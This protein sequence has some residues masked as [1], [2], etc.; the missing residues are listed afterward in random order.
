MG[1]LRTYHCAPVCRAC[2][3]TDCAEYHGAPPAGPPPREWALRPLTLTVT[4]GVR[5]RVCRRVPQ[6]G[7]PEP[8]AESHFCAGP[9]R[10]DWHASHVFRT[11]EGGADQTRATTAST[12][13]PRMWSTPSL[14]T[15]TRPCWHTLVPPSPSP[16]RP[17]S[18]PLT[19]PLL[20]PQPRPPAHSNASLPNDD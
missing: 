16:L 9:R 3:P 5:S 14:R 10:G 4:L 11:N 6:R 2:H 20:A 8:D 1:H 15:A 17:F 13:T 19:P 12:R 18:S 7:V